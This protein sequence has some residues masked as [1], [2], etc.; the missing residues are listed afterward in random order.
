MNVKFNS[1]SPRGACVKEFD[2]AQFGIDDDF[3]KLYSRTGAFIIA[4][5][6]SHI[7]EF[8]FIDLETS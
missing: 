1:L 7:D 2:C 6:L 5:R 4:F 3:L 8:G